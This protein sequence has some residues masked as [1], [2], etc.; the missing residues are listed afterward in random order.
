M[1]RSTFTHALALVLFASLV[2]FPLWA[3]PSPRIFFKKTIK[4]Q[5]E[6]LIKRHVVKPGEHLYQILRN[7]G[8]AERDLFQISNVAAE[9][10]PQI[11]D[12]DR[13][14]PGQLLL[15]PLSPEVSRDTAG[16]RVDY[17]HRTPASQN[18]HTREY[19][20]QSGDRIVQLFRE[21]GLTDVQIF[22]EYL[23]RFREYNPG[24]ADIDH[25]EVGDRIVIPLP[26][27]LAEGEPPVRTILLPSMPTPPSTTAVQE[28][29]LPS[30]RSMQSAPST[31]GQTRTDEENGSLALP[32]TPL[33]AE[34]VSEPLLELTSLPKPPPVRKE[35]TL[36]DKRSFL[37]SLLRTIG[38]RFTPGEELLYPVGDAGWFKVDL[39]KTPLARAPWGEQ[40][41]LLPEELKDLEKDFRDIGHTA[42]LVD[43]QWEPRKVLDSVAGK[44]GGQL[45]IWPSDRPLIINK[46]GVT[47][48]LHASVLAR[49]QNKK[50]LL[51]N[52]LEAGEPPT[53]AL[54]QAFF[55]RKGVHVSEWVRQP[56]FIPRPLQA[57]LPRQEDLLVPWLDR[58]NAWSE[59]QSRLG[60]EL[61]P[62]DSADID[63]VMAMLNRK[64]MISRDPVRI[65]WF[66]GKDREMALIVPAISI[67]DGN[68][69]LIILAQEQAS[70]HLVAL[71]SL[72]GYVCLAVR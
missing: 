19:R 65:S 55:A 53:P 40:Y 32:Q 12:L 27:E 10:N 52:L 34:G 46:G 71:L 37:L 21:S 39:K 57:D 15:V 48:E 72:K 18:L 29:D 6:K 66:W 54:L 67:N 47:L 51:L 22:S 59:I 4:V 70:P 38:F 28:S 41:V 13:L 31:G 8:V 44:S 7:Y 64:G 49:L 3:Q 36:A 43:E 23:R 26:K 1:T 2:G 11:Q 5:E 68:T 50:I 30:D 62:P 35:P 69:R 16:T 25:I 60:G 42:V 17:K 9:I 33:I 56:N 20:V 24:I 61:E 63:S 45:R 58:Y 14:V